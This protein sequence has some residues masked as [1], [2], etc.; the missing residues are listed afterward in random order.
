MSEIPHQWYF[1]ERPCVLERP[2]CDLAAKKVVALRIRTEDG[3]VMRIDVDEDGHLP[4][5]TYELMQ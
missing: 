4:G 2:I 5:V 1:K 3:K